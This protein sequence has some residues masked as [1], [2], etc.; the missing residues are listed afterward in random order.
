MHSTRNDDENMEQSWP[1]KKTIRFHDNADNESK[2]HMS[3]HGKRV[4]S[5]DLKHY[6]SR[7]LD[8]QKTQK[9]QGTCVRL[10]LCR[11]MEQ[12]RCETKNSSV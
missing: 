2:T 9:K 5:V 4:E 10:L 11:F 12:C 3:S 6:K 8:G 1:E 7:L